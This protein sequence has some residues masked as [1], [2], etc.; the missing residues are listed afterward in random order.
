MSAEQF[1]HGKPALTVAYREADRLKRNR[2]RWARWEAGVYVA[3]A[4]GAAFSKENKYPDEPYG[5]A[6]TE[7]EEK[8]RAAALLRVDMERME[9]FAASF[10]ASLG[11]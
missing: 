1:W 6:R 3:R 8:E 4:I 2:E 11:G 5:L 7:D 10:N 9:R